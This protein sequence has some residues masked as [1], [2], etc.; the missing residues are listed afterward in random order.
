[1][2]AAQLLHVVAGLSLLAACATEPAA[3]A[4]VA[5]QAPVIAPPRI[6][7]ALTDA[8]EAR[9]A[10]FVAERRIPG[11]AVAVGWHDHVVW[12]AA[13]GVTDLETKAPVTDTSVFPLGSTSKPLT[14]LV[15]GQLVEE[16]RL[17]L[18]APIQEY[19]PYFPVKEHVVT[20]R[21]L[22]GHLA[23][24]RDYDRAAG[25][26]D[27]TRHFASVREAVGVFADDPLL[28]APGTRH[29]Y[30]AYN[31]VLLSAALEGASGT[32]FLTLLDERLTRPLGL[33][34]TGP[35]RAPQPDLVTSY[36][37]G[38]FGRVVR[39][40]A[41]DPSNKWAAGGLVSTPLEMVQIGNAVL[42]GRVVE[43]ATFTL[44]TTPQPLADGSDSGAGYGLGWRS[45]TRTLADGRSV[46]VA[47]HGGTGVGSMS[48]FVLYPTEGLVVSLQSNLLFEPFTAFAAE[49]FA[50]AESFLDERR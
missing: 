41:T 38:F 37:S 5:T 21:Q 43:P 20:A 35:N 36:T 12:S 15:L 29:A 17:D 46:P 26:Y 45:G 49:A 22:A 27:N 1:M 33:V 31:F 25:E 32:D 48:F 28:F 3:Q 4:P 16:G 30:S 7:S 24:L 19:V 2:R 47:H 39:A 13:F 40:P 34:R 14:A 18:D 23:G 11:L 9:L 50:V 44:L 6:D 8:C 10:A 42:A